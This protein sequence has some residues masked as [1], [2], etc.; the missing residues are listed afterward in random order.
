MNAHKRA[1]EWRELFTLASVL[2]TPE[3][4]IID[5][6]YRIAGTI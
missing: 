2:E 4:E 1:L 3:E 6:G 5:I